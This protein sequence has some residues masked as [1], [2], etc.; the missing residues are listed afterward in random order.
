MALD[1][2]SATCSRAPIRF[3]FRE[4]WQS[5]RVLG[6]AFFGHAEALHVTVEQQQYIPVPVAE[7][8]RESSPSCNH[9]CF[10]RNR[11]E[12][13]VVLWPDSVFA[14]PQGSRVSAAKSEQVIDFHTAKAPLSGEVNAPPDRS[15]VF[16]FIGC[17]G[18]QH[19]PNQ[20]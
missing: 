16:A 4:I 17:A 8:N 12:M 10:G 15:I 2:L 9:R 5:Y 18:I 7:R 1:F 13:G 3:S 11:A 6:I 20:L 14:F 19:D